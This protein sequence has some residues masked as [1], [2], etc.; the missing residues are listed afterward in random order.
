MDGLGPPDQTSLEQMKANQRNAA[1]EKDVRKR[2]RQGDKGVGR[3]TR[4]RRDSG[5]RGRE[6]GIHFWKYGTGIVEKRLE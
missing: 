1:T 3:Q 6:V 2:N 5:P 4:G